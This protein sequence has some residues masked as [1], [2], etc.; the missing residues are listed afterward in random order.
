MGQVAITALL[1]ACGCPDEHLDEAYRRLGFTPI[2]DTHEA[3]VRQ[4]R[5]AI[6]EVVAR[7]D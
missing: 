6:A 7:H 4:V 2:P 1:V 3:L 5:A